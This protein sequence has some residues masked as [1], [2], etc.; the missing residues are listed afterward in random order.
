MVHIIIPYVRYAYMC[1]R[2]PVVCGSGVAALIIPGMY[3][4]M[5][6]YDSL[7]RCA[8]I[9]FNTGLSRTHE[10]LIPVFNL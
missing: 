5:W 6:N 4:R 2:L 9:L 3:M 7:I 8:A 10:K 1:N